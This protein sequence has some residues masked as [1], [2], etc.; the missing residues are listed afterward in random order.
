MTSVTEQL[1]IEEVIVKQDE[2]A[3]LFN[4]INNKWLFRGD[5]IY[6]I[7]HFYSVVGCFIQVY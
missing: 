1:A 3:K 4:E 6:K 5:I 7:E 2:A